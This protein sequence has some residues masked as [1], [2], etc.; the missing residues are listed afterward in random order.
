MVALEPLVLHFSS[1]Y[2]KLIDIS[3]YTHTKGHEVFVN[4]SYKFW[5]IE[6]LIDCLAQRFWY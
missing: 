3:Y 6:Q 4:L 1:S 5:D 2:C